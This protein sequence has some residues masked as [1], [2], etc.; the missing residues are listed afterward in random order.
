MTTTIA[1][2]RRIAVREGLLTEP[3]TDLQQEAL[4]KFRRPTAEEY[5]AKAG[6]AGQSD[7][8]LPG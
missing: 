6:H 8:Q 3:L 2:T 4:K 1:P 5:E 7:V